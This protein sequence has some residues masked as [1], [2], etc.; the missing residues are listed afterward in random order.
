M[1]ITLKL[2]RPSSKKSVVWVEFKKNAVHYKFYSGKTILTE[3][4][5]KTKEI[6]LSGDDNHEL[7]NKYLE[8]W[9]KEIKRI[10]TEMETNKE[11]LIQEVIQG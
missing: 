9:V 2:K 1:T 4:W 11:K 6:V 7:I 8:D 5:S 10:F 3:N